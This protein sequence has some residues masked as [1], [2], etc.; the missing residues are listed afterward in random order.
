MDTIKNYNDFPNQKV[1]NSEKKK[2]SWYI[3]FTNYI[4]ERALA[5][6]TTSEAVK[7]IKYANG[8]ID[9]D[10]IGYV[11]APYGKDIAQQAKQLRFPNNIRKLDIIIG[12]KERYIG[13]YIKQYHNYQ[14]YIHDSDSV[15][16]RNKELANAVTSQLLTTFL[17]LVESEDESEIE[18]LDLESFSKKFIEEWKDERVIKA[19][20]RLDLINDLTEADIKYIQAFFY[21]FACEEVYTYRTIISNELEKE[22]VPPYEYHRINSGNMFVEDDD[23]GMRKY[24]LSI[25]QIIESEELDEKDIDYIRSMIVN[26]GNNTGPVTVEPILLESRDA[27]NFYKPSDVGKISFT[28]D[29]KMVD[30]YHCVA[31]TQTLIYD[32]TYY[33]FL[34][35][36]VKTLEVPQDY[37]LDKAS[38]DISLS[39]KWINEV[40]E[41]KRYGDKIS[42]VYTP[43]KPVDVQRQEINN[44]NKCKLPYNGI[45]GLLANNFINPI[46]KR[47]ITYQ[48]LIRVFMFQLEKSVSKFKTFN[49]IPE[50][51]LADSGTMKLEHRLHYATVDDILPIKDESI[52]PVTY[53]A[54]KT[55]YNQGAEKLIS[56]LMELIVY[57]RKEALDVANMNEQRYGDIHAQAGKSVT[58]YAITKA[59]TG[60][61]LMFEMFNK[62][63]ERDYQADL[64]YSKAAWV[65]GKKGSYIDPN[66]K[67]VIYVDIDG[68]EELGT[69]IG[70]FIKNSALEEEKLKMYRELAFS[71][72]QNGNFDVA[73]DAITSENS[74][75]LR[76]L[77]KKAVEANKEHEAN[78]EK[79]RSMMQQEL[80][81]SQERITD[82]NHHQEEKI[83][84]LKEDAETQRTIMK[85]E[86]E[87][88]KLSKEINEDLKLDMP[89]EFKRNMEKANMELKKQKAILDEL[90]TYNSMKEKEPA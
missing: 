3:P 45:K 37:K 68:V 59:T 65:D 31:K 18:K 85:L 72:A 14:V 67:E 15:F 62:F 13:E 11:L 9:D 77:I 29:S 57:L 63:R 83:A 12:I 71:A 82:M 87:V 88:L 80:Q 36:E 23:M 60:S 48:E 28:D 20:K 16:I 30:V 32:L 69:N 73:A 44:S 24:K 33:D 43:A 66:T 61:I 17:K 86:L 42:G 51:L 8:I 1:R 27:F 41:S 19:Q 55:L 39:P 10:S 46:P 50:S 25:N 47:L 56:V 49:I 79:A 6:S 2:S 34:T 74:T 26:H 76:R 64:D 35:G 4:I 54:I 75:E 38:G 70:V 53:Q 22:I 58:E 84:R 5:E 81:A 7:N 90:K 78:L 40:W 52:D 21:W 89:D